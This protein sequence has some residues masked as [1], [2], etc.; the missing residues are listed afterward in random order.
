[1]TQTS[2]N[3]ILGLTALILGLVLGAGVA[4]LASTVTVDPASSAE[5]QAVTLSAAD[6][7][8]ELTAR[9]ATTRTTAEKPSGM[10]GTDYGIVRVALGDA[11]FTQSQ[12]TAVLASADRVCEGQRAGVPITTLEQG[13]AAA[14]G[15]DMP[16]AHDFVALV[17]LVRC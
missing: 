17:L 7:T 1:M 8:D 3:L 16:T 10:L 4:R 14:S 12:V 13:A 15:M 5:R 6:S 9:G 11:D 2:K